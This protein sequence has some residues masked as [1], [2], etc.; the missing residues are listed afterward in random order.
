MPTSLLKILQTFKTHLNTIPNQETTAFK[1]ACQDYYLA[2]VNLGLIIDLSII[3]L[4]DSLKKRFPPHKAKELVGLAAK[5]YDTESCSTL[6]RTTEI[7]CLSVQQIDSRIAIYHD[8]QANKME[9]NDKIREILLNQGF[10]SEEIGDFLE[11]RAEVFTLFKE[12]LG[13]SALKLRQIITEQNIPE[14]VVAQT[15]SRL[16]HQ[17]I[18]KTA[19]ENDAEFDSDSDSEEEK[20]IKESQQFLVERL[21]EM[22]IEEEHKQDEHD[23]EF[24]SGSDSEEESINT[25]ID[26]LNRIK[27][28]SIALINIIQDAVTTLN[29]HSKELLDL[30]EEQ[31]QSVPPPNFLETHRDVT[32]T[33]HS[34]I[35]R[36]Q[37][38]VAI[39]S[40][41]TLNL[42]DLT[43]EK[44]KI[45]LAEAKQ[46]LDFLTSESKNLIPK[47]K[48]WLQEI[49]TQLNEL[50]N[51]EARITISMV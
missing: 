23:T 48:Q 51:K 46:A 9:T 40:Q 17:N 47:A 45:S 18:S 24:D 12:K 49:D 36:L 21:R 39:V 44:I 38:R 22:E 29:C 1:R 28:E 32:E 14:D 5:F 16:N 26:T 27:N 30:C 31:G 37:T 33:W 8:I 43:E 34:F 42:N 50:R 41:Q 6:E 19:E 35:H 10:T 7:P 2:W 4:N 25:Y 13:K 20:A 11:K 3:T 15:L